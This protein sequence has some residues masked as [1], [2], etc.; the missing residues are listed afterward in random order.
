MC[1][2]ANWLK[3]WKSWT[4]EEREAWKARTPVEVYQ[5]LES[6]PAPR[7][8]KLTPA[9]SALIDGY[10]RKMH[11]VYVC[12]FNT[13]THCHWNRSLPKCYQGAKHENHDICVQQAR[14]FFAGCD[15]ARRDKQKL[16]LHSDTTCSSWRFANTEWWVT[17]GHRASVAL[18]HPNS[19]TPVFLPT[20]E[21]VAFKWHAHIQGT[22]NLGMFEFL[23]A[24]LTQVQ[25]IL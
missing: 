20:D 12:V 21:A 5:W 7:Q 16:E 13:Y 14:Q 19:C 9:G 1:D 23:W 10:M 8:C 18:N 22:I 3:G 2:Q 25:N 4:H 15:C 17:E 11:Q 24:E 6:T